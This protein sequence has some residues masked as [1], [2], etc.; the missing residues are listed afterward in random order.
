[1]NENRADIQTDQEKPPSLSELEDGIKLPQEKTRRNRRKRLALSLFALLILAAI[2]CFGAYHLM[3]EK[4]VDLKANKKLTEKAPSGE[5]IK[6]AAFDSISDSLSGP[7]TTPS[8]NFANTNIAS[9]QPLANAASETKGE[10]VTAPIQSG[11]SATLAPPPEA[12]LTK[13]SGTLKQNGHT[14]DYAAKANGAVKSPVPSVAGAMSK[15]NDAWSIR[16]ATTAPATEATGATAKTASSD[17]PTQARA[18]NTTNQKADGDQQ[19]RL[20]KRAPKPNFGAMLPVRLMGVLY[21]LSI[22]SLARLE[23]VRD[24]KTEHWRLKRGTV[25]I[26]SVTG[27]NLDRAYLQIKG[28]IDPDSQAF[29]KLEGEALGN[30]GGAGLRGKRRQVS[31]VWVK[32]LDRVAQ[33]GIQIGT[34][35]LNRRSSAVIVATDPYGVYRSTTDTNGASDQNRNFVEVAAGTVGFVL[36]TTLPESEA[37]NPHIAEAGMKAGT[38]TDDELVEL[39]TEADPARIRAAMSRMSPELQRVAQAALSE[40]EAR[41]P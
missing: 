17:F 5:D 31:P 21:T 27:G 37:S 12:L 40:I 7:V 33:A 39:M 34:G 29:I 1:M 6:R 24:H 22:G 16:Y 35:I 28:Y 13:D 14:T 9:G 25:F 19:P 32:V 38:L 15:S 20:I 10:R 2:T 18:S 4:T 3:R 8:P 26:G 23:L 11:I 41:K 30:D 36:V